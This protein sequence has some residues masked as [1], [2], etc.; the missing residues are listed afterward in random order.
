LIAA[1]R[2]GGAFACT[3]DG[4]ADF[5]PGSGAVV[6]L[7]KTLA[8]E[9]PEVACKAVDFEAG[10]GADQTIAALI[11]ELGVSDG[12]LEI[13]YRGGRRL[14]LT[15]TP[16]PLDSSGRGLA[17]HEES[18]VLITGGARGVT[19]EVALELARRFRLPPGAGGQVRH[20]CRIRT[21]RVRRDP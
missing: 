21:P 6:G 18:V 11:D 10:A 8:R 1:T 15:S 13:G 16:A 12:A 9:W 14:T 4:A 19:A 3:P 20:A 17:L 2:L 5:W 7:V